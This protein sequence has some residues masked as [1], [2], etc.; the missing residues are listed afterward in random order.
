MLPLQLWIHFSKSLEISHGE[1]RAKEKVIRLFSVQLKRGD[2]EL[3]CGSL[4]QFEIDPAITFSQD[5]HPQLNLR[6]S[7]G[8]K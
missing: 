5:F 1:D 8:V 2:V 7:S 6:T 4:F 3:L